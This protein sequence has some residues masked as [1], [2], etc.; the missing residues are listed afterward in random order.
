MESRWVRAARTSEMHEVGA[1]SRARTIVGLQHAAIA[2]SCDNF[3]LAKRDFTA[4]F[5][6]IFFPEGYLNATPRIQVIGVAWSS[7]Y[8]RAQHDAFSMIPHRFAFGLTH[9][10]V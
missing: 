1:R 4:N 6:P 8:G 7:A 2:N 10:Y 3:E 9:G 5:T